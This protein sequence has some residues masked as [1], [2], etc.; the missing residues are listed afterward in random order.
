MLTPPRRALPSGWPASLALA[1]CR[2]IPVLLAGR[3]DPGE[4]ARQTG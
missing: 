3:P 4:V 1:A 2:V